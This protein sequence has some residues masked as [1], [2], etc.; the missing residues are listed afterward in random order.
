MFTTMYPGVSRFLEVWAESV[1]AQTDTDFDLFVALDGMIPDQAVSACKREQVT[2]LP[3]PKG[4]SHTQVRSR[5]LEYLVDACDAVVFVDPDDVLLPGRVAA[6]REALFGSDITCCAMR[7]INEQG[8]DL[9]R[10]FDP[11]G[12]IDALHRANVFGLTNSSYRTAALKSCL[13]VPDGCI[14]MDWFAASMAVLK[15]FKAVVD[16]TSLMLYRQ[17]GSNTA[18][19]VSPF[20]EKHVLQAAQLMDGHYD[21]LSKA[22]KGDLPG[23]FNEARE[24][25]RIFLET[26]RQN[27]AV[28]KT[29]VK[30][31][32]SL[33]CD[34]VWWS[35]V[36][37]P[38][39]ENIWKH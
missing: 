17:Y 19:V 32:N 1:V 39:L 33:D 27:T 26:M 18:R 24:K 20:T 35:W 2:W 28:L 16:P 12:G 7:L 5:A 6:A 29:Y 15:D 37:H 13:P 23:I 9:G 14:L 25:V 11:V 30:A 34:H 31:L 10:K 3:A 4:V 38:L 22:V 21:C 8:K 36:A